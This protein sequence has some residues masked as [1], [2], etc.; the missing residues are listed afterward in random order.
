MSAPLLFRQMMDK[1][2]L[3]LLQEELQLR[4]L[5]PLQWSMMI[6]LLPGPL[7]RQEF[8]KWGVTWDAKQLANI[9]TRDLSGAIERGVT[10]GNFKVIDEEEKQ[11]RR[12]ISDG[13]RGVILACDGHRGEVGWIDFTPRGYA[14]YRAIR[15]NIFGVEVVGL[16]SDIQA[17]QAIVLGTT[18]EI[19]R[20]YAA[21]NRGKISF[22]KYGD[23]DITIE[24]KL[25]EISPPVRIDAW[26][27]N[28]FELVSS[29]YK[30][31]MQFGFD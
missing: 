23:N 21:E 13:E 29:G 4:R 10:E 14:L 27:Y 28:R 6:T 16:R 11:N 30:I 15:E 1:R 2:Q 17:N 7:P 9:T 25:L 12:I 26:R 22:H 5:E 8:A 3:S 18:S 24:A 31:V 20:Q 19:C